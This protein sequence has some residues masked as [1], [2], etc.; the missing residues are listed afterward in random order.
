MNLVFKTKILIIAICMT[1]IVSVEAVVLP[2]LMEKDQKI[3]LSS[4]VTY[5]WS[6]NKFSLLTY[7]EMPMSKWFPGFMRIGVIEGKLHVGMDTR[8]L[9]F[10]IIYAGVYSNMAFNLKKISEINLEVNP[11]FAYSMVIDKVFLSLWLGMDVLKVW[12]NDIEVFLGTR[13]FYKPM[14]PIY[15]HSEV[16]NKKASMAIGIFL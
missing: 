16:S 2:S 14:Y 10:D 6:I 3:N 11:Y 8:T 1:F 7:L 9:L 4:G 12:N 15:L 13:I 5:D